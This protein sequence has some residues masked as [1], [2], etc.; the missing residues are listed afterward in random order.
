[1]PS[2][3]F[4]LTAGGMQLGLIVLEITQ[5]D[6]QSGFCQSVEWLIVAEQFET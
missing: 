4:G 2:G 3:L 6:Y 5:R 1:M